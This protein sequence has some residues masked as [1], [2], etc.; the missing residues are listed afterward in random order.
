LSGFIWHC[1]RRVRIRRV[2]I[3]RVPATRLSLL[4]M[5]QHCKKF[6][7]TELV[8][9]HCGIEISPPVR[10]HCGNIARILCDGTIKMTGR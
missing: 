3:R 8:M 2:R 5:A 7:F 9:G 10:L 6:R 4:A 1:V